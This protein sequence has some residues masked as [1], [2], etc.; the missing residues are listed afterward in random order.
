MSHGVVG[1]SVPQS[2]K[3]R[4]ATATALQIMII[5][6]YFKDSTYFGCRAWRHQFGDD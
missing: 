6:L 4:Q 2:T 1:Q 5:R 3:V